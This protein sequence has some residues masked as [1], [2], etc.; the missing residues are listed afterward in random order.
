MI[1][2]RLFFF[3]EGK[4][5]VEANS[6]HSSKRYLRDLIMVFLSD[7]ERPQLAE[8]FKKLRYGAFISSLKGETQWITWVPGISTYA[9]NHEGAGILETT[10]QD[11]RR[12]MLLFLYVHHEQ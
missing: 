3:Q 9:K 4:R 7:S 8:I 12:E 5:G 1:K 11:S 10:F 2:R 6:W